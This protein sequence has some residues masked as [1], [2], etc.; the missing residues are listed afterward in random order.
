T[1]APTRKLRYIGR[2]STESAF[3]LDPRLSAD[4]AEAAQQT[5]APTRKL[6]YIGRRSTESAF[7]LD[8]RLSADTAE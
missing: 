6:R 1:R 7:T 2:R 8:P 4:T 5:R 3:T